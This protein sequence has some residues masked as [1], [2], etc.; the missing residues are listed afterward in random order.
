MR[1]LKQIVYF[2]LIIGVFAGCGSCMKSREVTIKVMTYNVRHG[3]SLSWKPSIE[4]QVE[5]IR[6]LNPVWVGLQEIDDKCKRSGSVDQTALFS[7]LTGLSGHFGSFMEYDSGRYGM[8]VL[9]ALPV[10]STENLILPEGAEPRIAIVQK[11]QITKNIRIAFANVHLDWTK[12]EFRKKQA[13]RLIAY[14]DSLNFPVVVLG[15]FNSEPG[16]PCM[17]IFF[18]RGFTEVQKDGNSKTWEAADPSVDIDHILFRD[19][20]GV[21]FSPVKAIV[22][23]EPEASDHRP[24][25][26]EIKVIFK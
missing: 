22:L 9:S 26:A 8:A 4:K 12:P 16:S 19:A 23:N 18:K 17:N 24:V 2:I 14:L 13:G 5:I 25:Q 6:K 1:V 15:D 11:V 21:H 3:V 10:L 7:K 20:R